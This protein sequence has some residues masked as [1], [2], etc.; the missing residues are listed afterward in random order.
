MLEK[1]LREIG[2]G[3]IARHLEGIDSSPLSAQIEKDLD[4]IDND[5]IQGLLKGVN[6]FDPPKGRVEPA[7]VIPASFYQSDEALDYIQLGRQIIK[8]GRVAALIVAGGQGSRLGINAPKGMVGVTPVLGKSLFQL[9]A[10]KILAL[11][12]R[13]CS[14]IPLFI[15][16]STTNDSQTKDFFR[17]HDYFG[18]D[19]DHVHFFVQGLLPSVTPEGRFILSRNQGLFMNPDG[20]GGTFAALKKNGCLEIMKDQGIEEIFYFQVDNPLVRVCDPL[21]I[22]LHSGNRAQMSSKVVRKRDFDEKVGVIARL[23]GKTTLVEY[24]DMDDDMRYATDKDKTMAYWAG[25]IAIH[26]IRRDFAEKITS[27]GVVLPFHKALKSIP[28]IDENGMEQEI[29]GVKFETF[30]FDALPLTD[31]SVTLEVKR[32]EEFAPVK[33]LSGDD[34]LESSIQMQSSL[35][36]KWLGDLGIEAS[37]GALIEISPLFAI[38]KEELSSRI[39][40]IPRQI[41]TDTFLGKEFD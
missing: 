20:H 11:S 25:S 19:K 29:R 33:N 12:K 24:S 31:S 21:F 13:Y 22:G 32:E 17:E 23:G 40:D 37:K 27:Q 8:E 38:D 2:Q 5:L 6:L 16:T 39:K 30:I 1:R 10:Q 34:S 14:V 36:K 18:L 28:T 35:Y 3:H 4:G 7:D 15:M 26:L 9:H 41:K